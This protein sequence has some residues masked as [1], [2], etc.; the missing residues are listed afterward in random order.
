MLL[1]C[2]ILKGF[3]FKINVEVVTDR[4]D[5]QQKWRFLLW[6]DDLIYRSI[7]VNVPVSITHPTYELTALNGKDIE[8]L[9]WNWFQLQSWLGLIGVRSWETHRHRVPAPWE[10]TVIEHVE[11]GQWFYKTCGSFPAGF[12]VLCVSTCGT[13]RLVHTGLRSSA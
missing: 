13:M 3:N 10:V 6:A 9:L 4:Y 5:P 1:W 8:R 11:W 2:K 7:T 12:M